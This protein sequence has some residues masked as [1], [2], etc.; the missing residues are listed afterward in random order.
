MR[1]GKE[2]DAAVLGSLVDAGL[3]VNAHSTGALIKKS[4]ARPEKRA[5]QANIWKGHSTPPP[6]HT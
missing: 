5:L 1:D 4:K 3:S 6:T 2:G